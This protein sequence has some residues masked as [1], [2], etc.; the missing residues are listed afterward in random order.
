M[1]CPNCGKENS[2]AVKFCTHCGATIAEVVSKVTNTNPVPNKNLVGVSGWLALFILGIFISSA[3]NI[4][5]SLIDFVPLGLIDIALGAYGLYVGYMLSKKQPAAVKHAKFYL[6]AVVVVST[7]MLIVISQDPYALEG[8]MTD[9]AR[10]LVYGIIWL[11]YLSAS[12]RVKA[13]YR[14]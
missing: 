13:T 10:G 14:G 8:A 6:A 9:S 12:K 5:T 2:G 7:I 3:I 4:V 1:Y 11:L